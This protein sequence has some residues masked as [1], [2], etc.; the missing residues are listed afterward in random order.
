MMWAVGYVAALAVGTA[1]GAA[2]MY[3]VLRERL[4]GDVDA[5]ELTDEDR[6]EITEQFKEHT[7]A[8]REQVSSFADTLAGGDPQLRERLRLFE[9][10]DR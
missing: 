4:C 7:R 1:G 8:V 3:L 2:A 9:S 5:H 10:G 6:S